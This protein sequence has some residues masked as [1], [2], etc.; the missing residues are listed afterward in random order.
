MR[1]QWIRFL[2]DNYSM[3]SF[4]I[5]PVLVNN[6]DYALEL[7]AS[8]AVINCIDALETHGVT[9]DKYGDL[10]FLSDKL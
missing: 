1:K 7:G 6:L 10:C 2:N 4:D 5:V 3:W 9:M 8:E